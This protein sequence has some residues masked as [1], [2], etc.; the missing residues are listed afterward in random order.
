MKSV[1]RRRRVPLFIAYP[2]DVQIRLLRYGTVAV[3][4][5]N[6]YIRDVFARRN[7]IRNARRTGATLC[8][9]RFFC[10]RV[11]RSFIALDVLWEFYEF[12]FAAAGHPCVNKYYT[13][14]QEFRAAINHVPGPTDRYNINAERSAL[15]YIG[16]YL[17]C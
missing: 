3:R 14:S 5:F 11:K 7:K 10:M 9:K 6:N 1:F 12:Y 15:P 2:R 8:T 4:L 13:V 16:I 17:W